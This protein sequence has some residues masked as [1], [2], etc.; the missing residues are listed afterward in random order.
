M[1]HTRP[2]DWIYPFSPLMIVLEE[3]VVLDAAPNP[4]DLDL[5]GTID[6]V[7][8]AVSTSTQK[9]R[10]QITCGIIRW[11]YF[12]DWFPSLLRR[13]CT[14]KAPVGTEP[15]II[16]DNVSLAAFFGHLSLSL[17]V[18]F[19]QCFGLWWHTRFA[20]QNSGIR[21]VTEIRG[22]ENSLGPSGF[23]LSHSF[24]LLKPNL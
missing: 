2:M 9:V 14:E 7:G 23:S 10:V 22:N 8:A 11:L 12:G 13:G 18:W 4:F 17:C 5:S 21:L 3:R 15:S 6:L 24:C 16:V 1:V 20:T 19:G